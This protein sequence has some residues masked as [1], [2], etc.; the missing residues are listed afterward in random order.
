VQPNNNTVVIEVEVLTAVVMKSFVLWDATLV[1][2]FG[3]V[4]PESP[5]PKNKPSKRLA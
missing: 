2:R 3:V 4:S 1:V 5:G